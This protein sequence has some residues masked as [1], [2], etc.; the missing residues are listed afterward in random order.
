[1]SKIN[2]TFAISV[3]LWRSWI[4][5]RLI[6][7]GVIFI[8][9]PQFHLLLYICDFLQYCLIVYY[10]NNI[11]CV[12]GVIIFVSIRHNVCNFATIHHTYG[13]HSTWSHFWSDSQSIS[14]TYPYAYVRPRVYCLSISYLHWNYAT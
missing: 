13:Q 9:P 1:M 2:T 7:N 5:G 8:R 14:L 4:F 11:I 3:Y 10:N 12:I 6:S